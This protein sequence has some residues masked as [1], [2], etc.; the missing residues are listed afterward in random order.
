MHACILCP[1][2]LQE[3]VDGGAILVQECVA[4]Q[5]GDTEG[6]LAERVRGVE[7]KAYPHALD[8]VASGQ[9]ALGPDGTAVWN[10]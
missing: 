10:M 7:H 8:L 2:V 6:S 5:P 3:E 9:V 4:V 1:H